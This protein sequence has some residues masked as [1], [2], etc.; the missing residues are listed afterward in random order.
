MIKCLICGKD[1]KQLDSHLRHKHL[2]S[3]KDYCKQFNVS[4]VI[5]DE[6]LYN[7]SKRY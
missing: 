1:F 4:S 3:S 6:S 7:I 2:I 5:S